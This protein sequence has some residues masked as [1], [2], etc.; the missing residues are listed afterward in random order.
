MAQ[1]SL[2][3]TVAIVLAIAAGYYLAMVPIII[4]TV[5]GVVV[6]GVFTKYNNSADAIPSLYGLIWY[7][8]TALLFL[9]TMW[10]TVLI[11]YLPTS[12]G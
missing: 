2:L 6:I 10:L 7:G 4:L 8:G 11:T 5:V 12:V 3:A 9:I 1:I